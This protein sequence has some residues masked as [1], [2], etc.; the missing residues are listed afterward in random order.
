[1]QRGEDGGAAVGE[2]LFD[3]GRDVRGLDVREARQA[4]E[5]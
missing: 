1:L 5:I 4:G 3:R 2:E